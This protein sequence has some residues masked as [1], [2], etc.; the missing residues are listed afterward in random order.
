MCTRIVLFEKIDIIKYNRTKYIIDYSKNHNLMQT[1]TVDN[2]WVTFY[3]ED[4]SEIT[5]C[6]NIKSEFEFLYS[7]ILNDAL[8]YER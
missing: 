8:N 7:N 6:F 2:K 3:F 1:M 4:N 5:E